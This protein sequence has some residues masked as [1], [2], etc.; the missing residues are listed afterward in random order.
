MPYG[1]FPIKGYFSITEDE[2]HDLMGEHSKYFYKSEPPA[3]NKNWETI[4][5][6]MQEFEEWISKRKINQETEKLYGGIIV[7]FNWTM[8]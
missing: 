7:R 1:D 8:G 3:P 5:V 6:T 4:A 2:L